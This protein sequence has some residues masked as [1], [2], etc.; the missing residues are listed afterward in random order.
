MEEE[1]IIEEGEG[2]ED[3]VKKFREKL[4]KCELE[5]QE[6]L[7]GWQRA[8]ADFINARK[9][10][11]ERRME[12]LKFCEKNMILEILALADSFERLF[13]DNQNFEKIDKNTRIGIENI[14]AQL[15]DILKKRGVEPMKDEGKKFNPE[16]HESLI[17]EKIDN[18][19]KEG[20]ILDIIR[21]GYKMNDVI[22]RSAQVKIGK[23]VKNIGN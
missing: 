13:G 16:E 21:K 4:K 17:E 12:F 23:Y 20:I 22:I 6:Y 1:I 15:M 2:L 8:K 11:E 5:K 18:P 9:E 10:D 19:E 14:Y 7:A 3:K